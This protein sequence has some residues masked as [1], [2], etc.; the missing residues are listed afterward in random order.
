MA[1]KSKIKIPQKMSGHEIS[2]RYKKLS[3]DFKKLVKRERDNF[4]VLFLLAVNLYKIN[5]IHE[6]FNNNTF[7]EEFI[8]M[9]KKSVEEHEKSK[10]TPKDIKESPDVG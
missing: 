3:D 7:N 2:R 9:I 8:E 10:N 5:P 4:G 1:K 6:I